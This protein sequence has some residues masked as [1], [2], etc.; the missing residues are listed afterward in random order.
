MNSNAGLNSATL[1]P[2]SN[3]RQ[4]AHIRPNKGEESSKGRKRL[5]V[6]FLFSCLLSAELRRELPNARQRWK[7]FTSFCDWRRWK[8]WKS[9]AVL[10]W[11]TITQRQESPLSLNRN[12][13]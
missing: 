6:Q 1:S 9:S 11:L 7:C 5:A 3:G 8:E 2:D 12:V 10:R 4:R 13:A